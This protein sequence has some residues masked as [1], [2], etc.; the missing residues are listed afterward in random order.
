[1]STMPTQ[2]FCLASIKPGVNG[3]VKILFCH[4]EAIL[5]NEGRTLMTSVQY[6]KRVVAWVVDEAHCVKIM[7]SDCI[8]FT[9]IKCNTEIF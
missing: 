6:Q 1:M 3:Q 9:N 8:L 2:P 7:V 5:N 4:P